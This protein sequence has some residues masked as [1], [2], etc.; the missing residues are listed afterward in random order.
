MNAISSHLDAILFALI[1]I[2]AWVSYR[3]GR[4]SA[5]DE[6]NAT[7]KEVDSLR[8]VIHSINNSRDLSRGNHPAGKIRLVH[9]E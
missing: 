6:I 4:A 7:L 1:C 2:V 3:I 5:Q 9:S 8:E